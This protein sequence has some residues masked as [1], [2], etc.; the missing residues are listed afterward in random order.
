MLNICMNPSLVSRSKVTL[1]NLNISACSCEQWKD[2][3]AFFESV[4]FWTLDNL[5]EYWKGYRVLIGL[6]E[7]YFQFWSDTLKG[8]V[9]Y[10][11]QSANN[12]ENDILTPSKLV[13]ALVS[14]SAVFNTNCNLSSRWHHS[15]DK[16]KDC[17]DFLNICMSLMNV[18]CVLEKK[19]L[20]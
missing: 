11:K 19:T 2:M 10:A 8:T 7:F 15:E 5:L 6:W 18:L 12:F 16:F 9:K 14:L 3:S 17:L 1:P 20:W 4:R 13:Y